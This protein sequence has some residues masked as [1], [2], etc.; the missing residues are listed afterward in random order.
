MDS[1]ENVA[2]TGLPDERPRLF[3]QNEIYG[4][5]AGPTISMVWISCMIAVFE[6]NPDKMVADGSSWLNML[7]SV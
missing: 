7:Q 1:W 6:R 4:F 5:N 2:K 3:N